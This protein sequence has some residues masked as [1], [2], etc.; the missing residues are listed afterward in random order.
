[1]ADLAK[2]LRAH[3]QYQSSTEARDACLAADEIEVLRAGIAELER[4]YA[5]DRIAADHAAQIEAIF[6]RHRTSYSERTTEGG[7]DG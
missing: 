1:M 2:R 5:T 4:L 3:F 7:E 6:D